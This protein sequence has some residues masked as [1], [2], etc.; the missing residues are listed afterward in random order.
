MA[1][2]NIVENADLIAEGKV[3]SVVQ[4]HD[5]SCDPNEPG[6]ACPD[7]R[8]WDAELSLSDVW[9]GPQVKFLV[10]SYDTCGPTL[11]AG[12]K[13]ALV[14]QKSASGRWT[15]DACQVGPIGTFSSTD[16]EFGRI[17]S[18]LLNSYREE[19]RRID[20][21]VRDDPNSVNAKLALASYQLSGNYFDEALATYREIVTLSPK[22]TAAYLEMARIQLKV[23][24]K[25]FY[26]LDAIKEGL[27]HVPDD[28][29]LL[30]FK[31][32]LG[33]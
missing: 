18:P 32:D 9:K 31:R 8:S 30:K 16:N 24:R 7:S 19:G 14:A 12:D 33:F 17:A 2:E 25:P 22:T 29:D 3:V 23:K 4:A 11:H 26:A 10:L 27:T 5:D 21:A 20:S 13:I 1:P 6:V 28:P 15:L